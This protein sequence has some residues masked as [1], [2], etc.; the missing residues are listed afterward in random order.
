MLRK[1]RAE[2]IK[3]AEL[4]SWEKEM[5]ETTLKEELENVIEEKEEVRTKR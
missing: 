3:N 2:A 1:E 4:T 5:V